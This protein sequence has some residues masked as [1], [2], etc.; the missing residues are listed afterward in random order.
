MLYDVDA[1][2]DV[3]P[4]SS[5]GLWLMLAGASSSGGSTTA[6]CIIAAISSGALAVILTA[7]QIV[8]LVLAGAVQPANNR[9]PDCRPG[10]PLQPL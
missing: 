6:A 8:T 3:G 9:K 4:G 7:L 10:C 1:G 2:T 5:F